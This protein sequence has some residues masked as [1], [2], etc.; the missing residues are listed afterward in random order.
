ML[1]LRQHDGTLQYIERGLNETS[2][3]AELSSAEELEERVSELESQVSDTDG[4]VT[5][6]D[7]QVC[8]WYT[9]LSASYGV[10]A[11]ECLSAKF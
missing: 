1:A 10:I 6:L 8:T 4:D 7:E 3:D 9:C 11:V 2:R 5:A